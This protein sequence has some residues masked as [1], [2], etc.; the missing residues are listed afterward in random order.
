MEIVPVIDLR[1]GL[2]VRG[3]S[4]ARAS[5]RP[6]MS[7]LRGG[8]PEDLSDPLA[9]LEAYRAALR[10]DRLYVADLDRIEGR[11]DQH[12]VVD[13]IA[14]AAPEATILLDAGTFRAGD[15]RRPAPGGS[16]RVVPVVATE[17]LSSLADLRET[18]RR[19]GSRGAAFSLDLGDRGVLSSSPEVAAVGE[20]DLL[21]QAQNCGFKTAILL[22]LGGVGTGSGLPRERLLR[23]RQAAPEVELLAGGGL[24][25]AADLEF[26]AASGFSGALV[27]TALHE[28]W[29]GL[30]VDFSRRQGSSGAPDGSRGVT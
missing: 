10:P 30:G 8:A 4:G 18:G 23:L 17:T 21:R 19:V 12:A 28:G 29:L 3:R 22:L 13:R 14:C 7:R 15:D 26:L 5:Y 25:T 20:R 6:V 1:G 24:A 2:A 16:L 11:G 9:L 27:G